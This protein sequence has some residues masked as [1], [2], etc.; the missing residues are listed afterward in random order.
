MKSKWVKLAGIVA[1]GT[2]FQVDL[3]FS[4]LG[5]AARDL[6]IFRLID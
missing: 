3:F 6:I 2:M 5:D 4:C 1:L